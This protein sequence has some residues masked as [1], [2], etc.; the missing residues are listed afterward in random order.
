MRVRTWPLCADYESC[1][2]DNHSV[3]RESVIYLVPFIRFLVSVR[4]KAALLCRWNKSLLASTVLGFDLGQ[5]H[6]IDVVCSWSIIWPKGLFSFKS[7]RVADNFSVDEFARCVQQYLFFC[8][9]N[10]V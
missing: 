6:W 4:G 5:W 2:G 9:K 8:L 3:V 1:Y 7:D 10:I